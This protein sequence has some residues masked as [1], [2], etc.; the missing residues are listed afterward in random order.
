M[1]VYIDKRGDVWQ[2]SGI[3]KYHTQGVY[4]NTHYEALV[5][6]DEWL[7]QQPNYDNGLDYEVVDVD[8]VR[9]P[10]LGYN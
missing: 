6:R 1:K 7:N 10:A 2:V 5:I 9:V 8:D 3:D 4:V